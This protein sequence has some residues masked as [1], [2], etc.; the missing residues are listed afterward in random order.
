MQSTVISSFNKTAQ[1][2]DSATA[3]QIVAPDALAPYNDF[4]LQEGIL[5]KF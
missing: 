5:E 1:V 4:L 2:D 3:E